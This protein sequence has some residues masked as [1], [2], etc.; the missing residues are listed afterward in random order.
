MPQIIQ[1]PLSV[2]RASEVEKEK[3][4]EYR[5]NLKSIT[6]V[7]GKSFTLKVYNLEDDAKVSFKS[8]DPSIASVNEN[9]TFKANK[10][11]STTIT[12]TV[13]RGSNSTSLTC[14]VKVGPPAFSVKMTRSII[15]LGQKQSALLEVIMKPSNTAEL[16][17]FSSFNSSIASVSSGGR[18][19]AKRLGMTYI[20]AEIDAVNLDGS[21]KFASCSVIVTKPEEVTQLRKYFSNHLELSLISESDLSAALYEF[22]NSNNTT[23]SNSGSES[24]IVDNLDKFLNS[25]FNLENLKKTYQERLQPVVEIKLSSQAGI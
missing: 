1:S 10:V 22:F 21:K 6:L 24:S 5:L 20:F 16:A 4:N 11:G 7:N 3:N 17:K 8:A 18:V 15:I 12:A 9:G 19:T 25:K 14:D 23:E 2:V 13:R